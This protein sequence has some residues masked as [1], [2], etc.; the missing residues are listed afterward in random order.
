M[1]PAARAAAAIDI[2]DAVASGRPAEQVLT[3]WARKSRFAGSGDRAAIR[4]IVFDVL[5]C[6]RSCA[7][8]G[9]G[10]TGRALVLGWCRQTGVDP[11]AV[12]SGV[13]HA[14]APLSV[15]EVDAG[16]DLDHPRRVR[17]LGEG[18]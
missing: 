10:E 6:W 5:R 15:S 1:T 12:F 7:W 2:L 14:P 8:L 16:R 18:L 4:D 17:A 9:G 3:T 13:G 11:E